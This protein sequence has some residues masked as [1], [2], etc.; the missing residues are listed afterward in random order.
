MGS[1]TLN[2]FELLVVLAAQRLGPDAHTVSITGDIAERTGRSVRRA[3]VY[4]ALQRLEARGLISTRLG[5]PRPE[6]GGKPRRLVTV[7]AD[8][9]TVA[10]ATTNAIQAMLGDAASERSR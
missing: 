8:G 10:R 7:T 6:R 9:A 5:D 1:D 3:N 2:Q 4:M